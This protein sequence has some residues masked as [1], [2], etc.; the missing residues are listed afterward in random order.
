MRPMDRSAPEPAA[1]PAAWCLGL[2]ALASACGGRDPPPRPPVTAVELSAN[3]YWSFG[4]DWWRVVYRSDLSCEW[5]GNLQ[6]SRL[7]EYAGTLEPAQWERVVACVEEL[8]L[9]QLL[10]HYDDPNAHDARHLILTVRRGVDATS[11]DDY[12]SAGPLEM[13]Q[14]ELLLLGLAREVRWQA[15][16]RAR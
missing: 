7:G 11:V 8:G 13:R 5:I 6:T 9:E 10:P 16:G 1:L 4:H 3:N 12:N 2:A 14:A 15:A